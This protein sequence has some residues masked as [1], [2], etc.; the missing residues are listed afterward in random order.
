MAMNNESIPVEFWVVLQ[1]NLTEQSTTDDLPNQTKNQVLSA[2]SNIRRPNIYD[3][4][5]D[6]L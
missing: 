4:A 5:P 3:R 2:F 1:V 6:S